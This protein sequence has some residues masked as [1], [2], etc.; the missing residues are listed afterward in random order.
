MDSYQTPPTTSE[1]SEQD[2]KGLKLAIEQASTG[3]SEGAG[4]PGRSGRSA[5]C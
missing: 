1:L 4:A 2:K 3:L 5:E